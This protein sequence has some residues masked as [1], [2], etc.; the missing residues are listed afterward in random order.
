MKYTYNKYHETENIT[1]RQLNNFDRLA[2]PI[3]LLVILL[4]VDELL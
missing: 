1:K 3:V 4:N 2:K